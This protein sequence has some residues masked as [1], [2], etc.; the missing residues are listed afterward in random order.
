MVQLGV[1]IGRWSGCIRQ[2][3]PGRLKDRPPTSAA[4]ASPPD[5]DLSHV[6]FSIL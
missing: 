3:D 1:W 6:A 5:L 2:G 4:A